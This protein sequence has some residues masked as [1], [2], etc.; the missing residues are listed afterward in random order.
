MFWQWNHF[1]STIKTHNA[2]KNV[3]TPNGSQHKKEALAS[4]TD[5]IGSRGFKNTVTGAPTG[6]LDLI[7][8]ALRMLPIQPEG[9]NH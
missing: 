3:P 7:F 8:S 6:Y 9:M 2:R 1:P 5:F 4:I